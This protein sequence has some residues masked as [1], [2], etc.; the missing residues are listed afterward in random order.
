M[1]QLGE[2]GEIGDA[3]IEPIGDLAAGVAGAERNVLGLLGLEPDAGFGLLGIV[4]G[5]T[6]QR[7]LAA[8]ARRGP[9]QLLG[10]CILHVPGAVGE[11]EELRPIDEGSLGQGG[12]TPLRGR[13]GVLVSRLCTGSSTMRGCFLSDS[14][15]SS[16]TSI[17]TVADFEHVAKSF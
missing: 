7:G 3:G 8:A 14:G 11:T 5:T 15:K 9:Q 1:V 17:C 12:G 13:A 2:A 6:A 16:R 10:R 4:A